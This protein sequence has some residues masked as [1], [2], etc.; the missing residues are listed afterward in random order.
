VLGNVIEGD[1][2]FVFGSNRNMS[3]GV[4]DEDDRQYPERIL[5]RRPDRLLRRFY[6]E[7]LDEQDDDT[8]ASSLDVEEIPT[9]VRNRPLIIHD[10][11]MSKLHT[12]ILTTD[13]V[14]NLFVSGLGRG[15][16]LGLGDENTLFK[17]VP[18]QGPLADKKIHQ[19][20][21]GQN[22]SMAVAGNG[23]LWTWG[24]N[25]DSQ[26]GFVLPPPARFDEEPMS[27]VPRQVFGSLKK[28]YIQGI[29][30]SAIHSVAHTGTSLFCWGR[31]VGQLALMDADSRS[32]DIQVT[33]RKVAASLLT[34]PITMVS[35]IDKATTC[36]LANNSVWVFTN[37][38]Y[39]LIKFP[40]PDVFTNH[41]LTTTSYSNRYDSGRRGIRYIA[42][43]G[44]TIAAVTARGDLFTMHVNQK[45][46]SDQVAGSTTNPAKIKGA[47][48]QPQCMWDS[49]K[50]GVVS[51]SV[52][53][54]GSVLICTESGAVWK[55][56]K[57]AKGKISAMAGGKRKDFKFERVPYITNCV[58]VRSS[59]FG[60]FSAIRKDSD[61]M[62]KEI[63]VSGKSLW[64]DLGALLCLNGFEASSSEGN[65]KDHRKAWDKAIV[66]EK[67]GSVPHELLKSPDV[68]SDLMEWLKFNAFQYDDID[69]RLRSSSAPDIMIPVHGWLLSA[70]S[71][72]IRS[73][74]SHFRR[75]GIQTHEEAFV[76]ENVGGKTVVTLLQADVMTLLNIVVFLYLD[77]SV[78]V[79]KY[80]REA[81]SFAHRFRHVRTEVMKFATRL[82]LPKLETAARLQ[83]T[84]EPSLDSDLQDAITD[85]RFFEDGDIILQLDGEDIPVHSQLLCQRCPFFEGMFNG[86]SQG[87]WLSGRRMEQDPAERIEIDLQHV[88]PE[89]FMLVLQYLYADVGEDM[90]QDTAV[91]SLD[92]FSEVVLDVMA[93][94]NELMLDRLSEACQS[95]L[96]KFVNTRNIAV[97]LNE[98]SPCSVTEFK[99]V[100]LEYICLQLESMLENC[101]LDGLDEDILLELDE[102]VRENQL[103]RLPFVRSGRAEL[104]LHE[105]YPDLM[106][107]IEEER[108]RRV[109]EFAF[110]NTQ[111][112]DERK[113]SASY[114]ARV[115]SFGEMAPL[116]QTPDGS[117]RK[118][119]SG[120]NEPF[121]PRLQPKPSQN[122]MIFEM[123]EDGLNVASPFSPEPFS[124]S[125]QAD[126]DVEAITPLPESAWQD[127]KGKRASSFSK[128]PSP[129]NL[130]PRT[131]AP[132]T[133]ETPS[134][135]LSEQRRPNAPWA[136]APLSTTKL[137]LR[138]IMSEAS[139]KPKSAL[140]A[141]LAQASEDSPVSKAQSKMSQKERKKQMQKQAEMAAA[142]NDKANAKPWQPVSAGGKTAPWKSATPIPKTSLQ[143]AMSSDAQQ[144]EAM[145]AGAKPL[146][147]SETDKNT[148]RRRTASPDTRFPG[149]NRNRGP[150]SDQVNSKQ[151]Q[152]TPLVPH[153]KSYITSPPKSEPSI[154]ASMA[155]I[156]GQQQREQQLVKEAVAKRSLQE[157]QQEQEFQEWWDQES[158]RAQ[159]E[160]AGRS[161][162]NKK[163]KDE[164]SKKRGRGG[165]GGGAENR[166]NK[167]RDSGKPE[168]PG[169]SGS[170]DVP[171]GKPGPKR[172]QAATA[173]SKK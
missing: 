23:E 109:K 25:S 117:R 91:P 85:K 62:S 113:L 96:G 18:V 100:G 50:D 108:Q 69:L 30:A 172:P 2:L 53:E 167:G 66:R 124:P 52:G 21:L 34:A 20:A 93:T 1:E 153:S 92:E 149:Q 120:R 166:A 42:S 35:A 3:L 47:V 154:G 140:T 26:L 88:H 112:D 31:N 22:H 126:L 79:W 55:R 41:N 86:R 141:S 67:P 4:G 110:K 89:T 87:E 151:Q 138:G 44:D 118:S 121:S 168:A 70:R 45:T 9:L 128:S 81:P 161:F 132:V 115:G 11:A 74:L 103:A 135:P 102:I 49:R 105:K 68:E 14:C 46:D 57:R 40:Y 17:F 170:K 43:G 65:N 94:A 15:G 130:I 78:P 37:Y 99:D 106:L 63:S 83:S 75:N 152:K 159:E 76:V 19:V 150:V 73:A 13:P 157:I 59:T 165:R 48:S 111:K 145:L 147:A 72:I 119:R 144:R 162:K 10:V 169:S 36:L 51:V 156:I 38:G 146:V 82:Q 139:P 133:R 5:L 7:Y 16:R 114:K 127:V 122:E 61:V 56:I 97:L 60:A 29:A 54:H 143:E 58:S 134:T 33:P 158:R 142:Q 24:L 27:L 39:S 160:E 64:D 12:A 148:T 95:V 123:E 98:I 6:E 101:L 84:V 137:D 77:T 155:D 28:E 173:G 125:A 136:G 32:L 8:I 116:S 164:G 131:E 90:F 104:L 107:D 163:D 71:M 80:T 129:G 171:A